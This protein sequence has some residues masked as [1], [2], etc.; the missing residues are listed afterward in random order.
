MAITSVILSLL[1]EVAIFFPVFLILFSFRNFFKAWVASVMGDR[2][3]AEEGF[4]TLNPMQHIDVPLLL[5]FLFAFSL[6]GILIGGALPRKLIFMAVVLLG[7]YWSV[8]VPLD[9]SRLTPPK[10]GTILCALSSAVGMILFAFC[11]LI[12]IKF[13]AFFPLP[14]AL[15]QSIMELL[16]TIVGI[17]LFF[18]V[19]HLIPI[20]PLDAGRIMP[21]ILPAAWQGVYDF[22]EEYSLYIF[23]ILF[24]AP[25]TSDLFLAFVGYLQSALEHGMIKLL[26]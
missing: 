16:H 9:E 26:F 14:G 15:A 12:L 1:H 19:I 20:P 3:A 21:F 7:A 10:L 25:I 24:F 4:L 8:P 5:V 6:V 13:F 23:L 18:G 11:T 2:T 17:A 22:C